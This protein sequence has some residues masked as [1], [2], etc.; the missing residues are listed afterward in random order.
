MEF[1][2]GEDKVMVNIG[3]VGEPR[4]GDIRAS[5]VIL[6]DARSDSDIRRDSLGLMMPRSTKVIYRRVPYDYETTIRRIRGV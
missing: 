1:A 3:S 4:D 2:L 5:Y 6:E